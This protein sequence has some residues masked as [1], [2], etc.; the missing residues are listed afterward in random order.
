MTQIAVS[1]VEPTGMVSF[2]IMPFYAE[3]MKEF[4]DKINQVDLD[5]SEPL[6][7]PCLDIGAALC[8]AVELA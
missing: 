5:V 7:S 2:Q 6:V 3:N 8:L 1:D 4:D